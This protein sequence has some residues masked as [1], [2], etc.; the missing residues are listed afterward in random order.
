M[1]VPLRLPPYQLAFCPL[2]RTIP[3]YSLIIGVAI[4]EN[5]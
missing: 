2:A 5:F 1:T 3:P 4:P